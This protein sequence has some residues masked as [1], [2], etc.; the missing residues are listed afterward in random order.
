MGFCLPMGLGSPFC[1]LADSS[2]Q[3]GIH[4]AALR[5]LQAE[6]AGVDLALCLWID[7]D[8]LIVLGV[9]AGLGGLLGTPA[10]YNLAAALLQHELWVTVDVRLL[11]V[12][13]YR[14]ALL[15]IQAQKDMA[16]G[17]HGSP[18][19]QGLGGG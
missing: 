15:R 16:H 10:R 13:Q 4:L 14:F 12:K 1:L 9:P 5:L 6:A 18:E 8:E 11:K 19:P 2:C 3:M 17:L 7:L